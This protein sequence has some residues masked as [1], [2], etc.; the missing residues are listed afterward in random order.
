MPYKFNNRFAHANFKEELKTLSNKVHVMSYQGEYVYNS[1]VG[2]RRY[3][4]EDSYSTQAGLMSSF[5]KQLGYV[6][7]WCFNPLQFGSDVSTT[8]NPDWFVDGS[9]W[10]RWL[11]LLPFDEEEVN[12]RIVLE[13][14]VDP[15]RLTPD[16]NLDYGFVSMLQY[17]DP[18]DFVGAYRLKYDEDSDDWFYPTIYPFRNN[19]PDA[20]FKYV[21]NFKKDD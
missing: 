8:F 15:D 5:K 13:L 20:T 9:L 18:K 11:E 10:R 17:I 6:P 12:R 1:I 3:Y 19:K 2:G 4:A 7:I 21:T 16:A 14:L